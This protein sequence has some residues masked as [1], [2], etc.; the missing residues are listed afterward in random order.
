MK[1][2][3]QY[4]FFALLLITGISSCKK[5]VTNI[6][7]ASTDDIAIMQGFLNPDADTITISLS[8]ASGVT[9]NKKTITLTDLELATVTIESNGIS[10]QLQ[11]LK[12]ND[13]NII[14]YLKK[15]ELPI[16]P[17]KTYTVRAA[18]G[19]IF[20][21]EASTTVPAEK[22]DFT[23]ESTGPYETQYSTEYRVKLNIHDVKGTENYYRIGITGPEY[24]GAYEMEYLTDDK[25]ALSEISHTTV[26]DEYNYPL[27][28]GKVSVSNITEAY[29]KFVKSLETVENSDGNPFAEPTRLYSNVTGGIGVLASM[30]I[31]Y[32]DL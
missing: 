3:I 32:K 22:A 24:D 27:V 9:R 8:V 7:L 23:F 31:N 30:N 6:P 2:T 18:N 4:I 19:T 25:D 16:L 14:F 15:T 10:K 26:I 17:G 1:S 21:L 11:V 29:Y 12:V 5:E 20:A 13:R 28:N